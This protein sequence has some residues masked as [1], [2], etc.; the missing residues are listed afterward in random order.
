MLTALGQPPGLFDVTVKPLAVMAGQTKL[1]DAEA[2]VQP[3]GTPLVDGVATPPVNEAIAEMPGTLISLNAVARSTGAVAVGPVPVSELQAA[4][5]AT[6]AMP[7]K[8]VGLVM[9]PSRNR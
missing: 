2:Y 6:V 8:R 5:S 4:R 1:C 7:R 3:D 9:G